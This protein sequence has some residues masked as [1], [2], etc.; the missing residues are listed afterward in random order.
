MNWDRV[1][2]IVINK[3]HVVLAAVT[4]GAIIVFHFKT[5][6]DIGNGV[7]G[8]VYAWYGFLAG[9][10]L[11]YQKWPDPANADSTAPVPA[12]APAPATAA[13]ANGTGSDDAKG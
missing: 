10:A 9:H 13:P 3:M 6:K 12:A 4:Q 1:Y 11:T 5:G 7:Q 8:T 2:D